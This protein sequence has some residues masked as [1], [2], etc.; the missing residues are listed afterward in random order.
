MKTACA[1]QFNAAN[2]RER[3][4]NERQLAQFREVIS[5]GKEKTTGTRVGERRG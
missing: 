1:I 5:Y 3:T 4:P 2:A